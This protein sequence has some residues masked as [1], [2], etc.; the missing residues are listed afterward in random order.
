MT[1]KFGQMIAIFVKKNDK[2]R[3]GDFITVKAMAWEWD[4]RARHQIFVNIGCPE[5]AL[6]FEKSPKFD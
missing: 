4:F 2:T 3:C 5:N 6:L 1:C